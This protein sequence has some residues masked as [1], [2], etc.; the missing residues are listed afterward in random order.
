MSHLRIH[1]LLFLTQRCRFTLDRMF[2]KITNILV[3]LHVISVT[4]LR[5]MTPLYGRK[6]L[7]EQFPHLLLDEQPSGEGSAHGPACNKRFPAPFA[8]RDGATAG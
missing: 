5:V 6:T 2:V 1:S 7:R 8:S 3:A 4:A